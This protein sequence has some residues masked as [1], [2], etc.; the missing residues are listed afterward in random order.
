[1]FIIDKRYNFSTKAPVTL[2]ENYK[3]MKAVAR[4]NF[5]FA[6]NYLDVITVHEAIANEINSSLNNYR[7][8]MYTVFESDSGDTI[9]ISD[10][11]VIPSSVLAINNI[12]LELIISDITT[13]DITTIT[14]TL[15]SLNY[16][17]IKS[18]IRNA[19]E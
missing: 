11:W 2:G 10:E 7:D 19:D 14:N 15:N 3:N 13:E 8:V 4:V 5:T 16:H 12:D 18:T 1:M 9:V 17:K 6:T